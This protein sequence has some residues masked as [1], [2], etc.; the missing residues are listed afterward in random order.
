MEGRFAANR[1]ILS[2]DPANWPILNKIRKCG[3]PYPCHE[4]SCEKCNNAPL[5]PQAW[6]VDPRRYIAHDVINPVYYPYHV[7][8]GSFRRIQNITKMIEPF[9]GLPVNEVAPFTN[10]FAVFQGGEDYRAAKQFYVKWMREIAKGFKALVH[11]EVKMT[12][13]F[14]RSWTTAGQVKWDLP[15]RAPGLMDVRDMDPDQ[16]VCLFHVH[17]FAHFPGFKYHE[18]GQFFRMVFEGS[19]QVHVA[20]PKLDDVLNDFGR[21]MTWPEIQDPLLLNNP[22]IEN[23]HRLLDHPDDIDEWFEHFHG[24]AQTLQEGP[25]VDERL[26]A[27]ADQYARLVELDLDQASIDQNDL[28]SGLVGWASYCCKDHLPKAKSRWVDYSSGPDNPE[29]VSVTLTDEQMVFACHADMEIRR[30]LHRTRMM[31]SFGTIERKQSGSGDEKSDDRLKVG[32][33]PYNIKNKQVVGDT[34]GDAE[35]FVLHWCKYDAA[36]ILKID[37]PTIQWMPSS[38]ISPTRRGKQSGK[39]LQYYKEVGPTITAEPLF[40]GV[41]TVEPNKLR[42]GV[43]VLHPP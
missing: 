30:A 17:G 36:H 6:R 35:H 3:D 40:C 24:F 1:E 23:K 22:D 10:K 34:H 28:A 20:E 5:D 8:K 18:A 29:A 14:E 39:W 26:D 7:G 21:D 43:R 32:S 31:H 19:W 27:M 4:K 9:Y 37:V 41:S 42:L 33:D 38:I 15:F 16:V 13:R 12:Y 2:Y 25:S 11:P